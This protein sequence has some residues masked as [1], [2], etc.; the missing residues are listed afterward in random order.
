MQ[1]QAHDSL[2]A[3][4]ARKTAATLG[5]YVAILT[6]AVTISTFA[7]AI[8]TP[9]LSGPYCAD[10]PCFEYPYL[11]D[12][13]ER[14]PRDYYWMYPAI[15]LTLLYL[16][17]M[18]C[19]HYFA[20]ESRRPVTHFG[21]LLAVLATGIIVV[22]YF[23]QVSVVQIS[24]EAGETDGIALLT[25]YNP[26][27]LFIVLEDVGY[28]LMGV[29]FAFAAPAFTGVGRL[30]QVLRV[31]LILGTVAVLVALSGVVVMYGIERE[32]RF[33]VFAISIDWLVLVIAGALLAAI[34]WRARMSVAR[35]S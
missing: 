27:G 20:P 34:F 24:L 15:V 1:S 13:S 32:Y 18:V 21:M 3:A 10:E 25:Q 19:I 2:A 23:V 11:E 9:P 12:I 4:S 17:L 28:L 5:F 6:V 30:E 16:A 26:H 31:V 29:S 14:F 35:S 8:V 22:D 33:E 7:R